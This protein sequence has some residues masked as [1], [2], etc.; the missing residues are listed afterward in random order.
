MGEVVSFNR[1]ELQVISEGEAARLLGVSPATLRRHRLADI[2][3]RYVKLGVRRI[4]YRQGAI[5]EWVNQRE[6]GGHGAFAERSGSASR[7]RAWKT[8]A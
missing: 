5:R 6:R 1:T 3:P 8:A 4:G 2:G 7:D